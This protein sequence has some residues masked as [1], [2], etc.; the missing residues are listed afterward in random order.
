VENLGEQLRE[1]RQGRGWTLET[2]STRSGLST[3]F[4]SQVERGQSTLSIV[5]LSAICQALE[6]PIDRLFTSSAPLGEG[7]ARVTKAAAQLRIQI[8]DSVV[9]YRY[10]TPQLPAVPVEE[11]LIAELPPNARQEAAAHDGEEFGFV[12]EGTLR[13]LVGEDDYALATGDSYRV[14]S[15]EQ[16]EYRAGRSGARILMAVTQRFIV[17]AARR[18]RR[19]LAGDR[20]PNAPTSPERRELRRHGKD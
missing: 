7:A 17:S 4:L 1:A 15:R 11:L 2:L 5:S 13:L 9:S 14:A 6:I 18:G 8:G 20:T 16:H 10:L 19:I 12:L 3:G